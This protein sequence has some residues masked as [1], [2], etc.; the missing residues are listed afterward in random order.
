MPLTVLSY[1]AELAD[2]E[3][4]HELTNKTRPTPI[5]GIDV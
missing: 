2:H 4:G 5:H 1:R 3:P